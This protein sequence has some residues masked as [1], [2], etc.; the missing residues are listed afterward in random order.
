MALQRTIWRNQIVTDFYA[1]NEFLSR[2]Q[3]WDEYVRDGVKTVIIP[4]EGTG[5]AVERN[6]TTFPATATQRTDGEFSYEMVDYTSTPRFV[7]N[8]EEIQMSYAKMQSAIAQD[9]ALVKEQAA[10]DIL[11][12]WRAELANSIVRTSG[13]TV[14]AMAG[15][16]GNRKAI[17][18][19]DIVKAATAMNEA[20]VPNAG[21]VI[22]LTPSQIQ[23]LATDE[24]VKKIGMGTVLM[25][26]NSLKPATL[27]GF[28]VLERSRVL[29][30]DN[31]A[32]PVGKVP[33]A[34]AAAADNVAAL[35]W[36]PFSV[37]R[38]MGN[39]EVFYDPANPLYYGN[40]FSMEVQAGGRKALKQSA[41]V[42]A[43]VQ[44]AA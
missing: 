34:A 30:Y 4:V 9:M 23:E 11:Y 28:V 39:V 2:A 19:Q 1:D 14:P 12:S 37:G 10:E 22:M 36:S 25:N 35:C 43:I 29:R 3:N 38:S 7:T 31:S 33:T 17:T 44:A 32:T 15:A 41:G 24:D 16:T 6:R 40:V 26:Y 18:F 27:A 8:L 5:S 42:V 13:A 21:R 20:N